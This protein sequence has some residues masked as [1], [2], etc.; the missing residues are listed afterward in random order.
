MLE[1]KKKETFY[2]SSTQLNSNL[3]PMNQSDTSK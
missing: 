2:K 1:R 3:L